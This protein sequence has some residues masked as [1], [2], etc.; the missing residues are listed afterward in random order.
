MALLATNS[1]RYL[2]QLLIDMEKLSLVLYVE[3]SNQA[4][5]TPKTGSQAL[6][7]YKSEQKSAI[8][9]LIN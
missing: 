4:H 9:S 6:L 2:T 7:E 1:E 5:K 3:R 8:T